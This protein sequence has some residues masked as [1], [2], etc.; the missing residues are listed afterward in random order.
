V[1]IVLAA[2]VAGCSSHDSQTLG[3]TVQ[4]PV[5]SIA[6]LRQTPAGAPVV[7][8]GRLTE[9]CPVAGCW[10][11]LHDETGTIKIDTKHAGFVVLNVPLQ[12]SVTVA[13][14][15]VTNETE[16]IIDATGM[17]Y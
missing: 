4:G 12:T 15:V 14:L 8:H 9:K 3:T 10:F 11:V 5:A 16:R 13:G 17:R 2:L 1:W 6:T 7:L